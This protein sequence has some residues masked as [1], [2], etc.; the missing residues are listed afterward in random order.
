VPSDDVDDTKVVEDVHVPSKTASIIED[1]SV[2]SDTLII[3]EVD[4][5]S[6]S[7][8]DDVDEIVEPNTPAVPSKSFEFSY[9]EYS[10]MVVSIDPSSSESPELFG[11][12][13][14]MVSSAS[15]FS[16][17]LEFVSESNIPPFAR[18][19]VCPPRQPKHIIF[20]SFRIMPKVPTALN[21]HVAYIDDI[22]RPIVICND[23]YKFA[24]YP[25]STLQEFAIDN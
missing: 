5:P 2:G 4:M 22:T 25:Y 3:D 16:G 7:T 24:T 23:T 8:I 15:F 17:C 20:S 18:L 13:Q 6:D 11:M 21:L 9:A 1:I 19:N 12:I 14:Q 10:F